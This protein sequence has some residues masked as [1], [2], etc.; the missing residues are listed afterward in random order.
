MTDFR[1]QIENFDNNLSIKLHSNP[2]LQT[3]EEDFHRKGK[4]N[5]IDITNDR[6]P[7]CIVW[8]L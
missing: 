3:M 2:N 4:E 8:Y 5:K 1:A 7:N 6:F